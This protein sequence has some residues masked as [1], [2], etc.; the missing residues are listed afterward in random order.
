MNA[1]KNRIRRFQ[2]TFAGNPETGAKICPLACS[3]VTI[4]PQIYH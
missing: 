2:R 4:R 3:G 1:C